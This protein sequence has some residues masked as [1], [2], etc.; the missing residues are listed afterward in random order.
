V[1]KS[2]T[3]IA[4]ESFKSGLN[5]AQAVFTCFSEELGYD[6]EIAIRTT[7]GFGGG[8]GRMGE[9][10]GAVTGSYMVLGMI[11]CKKLSDNHDRKEATYMMVRNFTEKFK[12]I[13]GST[14]CRS[15]LNCEIGTEEGHRF[16]VENNLFEKVCEKCI[17]D[18]I[19]IIEELK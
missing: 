13:N 1:K 11:N 7:C 9:T 16:A 2:A 4:I 10:C 18:S 14:E 5:C 12:V 6:K 17:K 15:L 19:R 8:M 3:E